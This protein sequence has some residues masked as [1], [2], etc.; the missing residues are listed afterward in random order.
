MGGAQHVAVID[1][2]PSAVEPL[3]VGETRHPGELVG[4]CLLA[5]HY[6]GHFVPLATFWNRKH[7]VS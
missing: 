7:T 3:E 4:A 6:A 5:P 2:H 1:E